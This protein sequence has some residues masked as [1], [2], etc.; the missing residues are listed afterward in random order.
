MSDAKILKDCIDEYRKANKVLD[1]KLNK[2]EDYIRQ[3]RKEA[4]E[5]S[6]RS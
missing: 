3:S 2:A 1:D 6:N 5:Q 4:K